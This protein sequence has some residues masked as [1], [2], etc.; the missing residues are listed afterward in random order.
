MADEF[1]LFDDNTE[2]DDGTR[3]VPFL[4]VDEASTGGWWW[5]WCTTK[6]DGGR[7]VEKDEKGPLVSNKSADVVDS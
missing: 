6:V 3:G 7:G 2:D 1:L 4:P 5:W